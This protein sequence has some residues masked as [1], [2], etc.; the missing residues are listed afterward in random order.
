M[1]KL[2]LGSTPAKDD[3]PIELTPRLASECPPGVLS[4]MPKPKQSKRTASWRPHPTLG[5]RDHAFH[6]DRDFCK[7][8]KSASCVKE[9]RIALGK[10]FEKTCKCWIFVVVSPDG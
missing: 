9:E 2:S 1:A 3:K 6:G 10:H 4:L 8:A 7:V 5:A